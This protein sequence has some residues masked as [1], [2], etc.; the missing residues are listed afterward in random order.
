MY[1]RY[2]VSLGFALLLALSGCATT[3]MDLAWPQPR[4]LG[5]DLDAYRP[6]REPPPIAPALPGAEEPTGVITLRQALSL[7]LMKSPELAASSWEVRARE[8]STLQAALRP[9]PEFGTAAEYFG[10]S[11]TFQSFDAAETT[12]Q[13]SQLIEL[14]GRRSKRTRVAALERDLSGW[15]YET[16]RLDVLTEAAKAF[17][18]V[19]VAQEQLALTTELARL[20][21]QVFT[22]VSE[23]VKA[24][25]VS[26]V[27]ETKASVALANSR[28]A[29]ERDKRTLE[30]ARK[31]LAATWG[32]TSPTFERVDGELD[33]VAPI[34]PA[35]WFA[36]K[37]SQN[38]DVARWTVELQRRQ[39]ALELEN[40]RRFPDLTLGGGFRRL[41]LTDDNAL[42]LGVSAPLPIFDRNPGGILEAKYR[43]AKAEEE[44]RA[45]ELRVHTALADAY[46]ALATA[47]AEATALRDEVVPGAQSAF[48]AATE[49][50]RLGKFSYLDVLDAQRTLFEARGRY[51]EAL[52]AYHKALADAERLIGERIEAVSGKP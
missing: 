44:R 46:Q 1:L 24:G 19:L 14:W 8:A 34:P 37:I 52:A 13:L 26:P 11:G 17:V 22:T 20:A 42:I 5:K 45:A 6:P 38:P 47:F 33:T 18:D 12:L 4:A 21:E 50:Y 31:R 36:R 43:L 28:I 48:E 3:Q 23:R 32:G 2:L 29:V 51:I 9:N 35:D 16:K 10:G 41:N 30:G 40:V 27:E 39:A 25:K 7:A 49:G 15:D